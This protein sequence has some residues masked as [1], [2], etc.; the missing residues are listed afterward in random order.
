MVPIS[1]SLTASITALQ[2]R[3]RRHLK[4]V[5]SVLSAGLALPLNEPVALGFDFVAPPDEGT[6]QSLRLF[7]GFEMM[8][9]GLSTC[10]GRWMETRRKSNCGQL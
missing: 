9:S 1:R 5:A 7:A 3:F 2:D 10:G 4:P 8:L 6:K